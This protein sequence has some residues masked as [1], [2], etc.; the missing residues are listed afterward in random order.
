[1]RL[2]VAAVKVIRQDYLDFLCHNRL[3][4]SDALVFFTHLP[5]VISWTPMLRATSATD[6]FPSMTKATA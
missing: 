1:F 6:R 4:S 5:N 3:H 2:G